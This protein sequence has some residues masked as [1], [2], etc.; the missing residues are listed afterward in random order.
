MDV[1][2]E[3]LQGHYIFS[4]K[5]RPTFLVGAFDEQAVH[6]YIQHTLEVSRGCVIEMILKDTHTCE[7]HPERF[8]RWTSIARDLAT[9]YV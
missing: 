9:Q 4:W 5:P 7:N 8:T 1:S 2:A 6:G 3:R